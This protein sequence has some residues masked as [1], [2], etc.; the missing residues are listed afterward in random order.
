MAFEKELFNI[1]KREIVLFGGKGGTGKTSC[2]AAAGL[3]A[4][5][6][7]KKT[8]IFSTDPAHSLSDIF[9]QSI[10]DKVTPI[11]GKKNLWCFEIDAKRAVDAE[12]KWWIPHIEQLLRELPYRGVE[13]EVLQKLWDI[14]LLGLDELLALSELNEI[15]ETQQFDNVIIDTAAGAHTIWMTT[16]PAMA[17]EWFEKIIDVM[18]TARRRETP[19][20]APRRVLFRHM[21]PYFTV[22]RRIE[23]YLKKARNLKSLLA[24]SSRTTFVLVTIAERMGLYVTEDMVKD[25]H[26]FWDRLPQ[27][28]HQ[29]PH[30]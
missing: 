2:A 7:G 20:H 19:R 29:L 11:E 25:L 8:L 18:E 12:R 4:A 17:I 10:G 15:L 30:P 9:G 27:H 1:F 6:R 13:R 23:G 14:P 24:D 22:L 16:I 5:K 3:Y 21:R 26:A 28:Y